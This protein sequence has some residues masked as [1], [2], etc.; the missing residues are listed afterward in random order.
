LYN[1]TTNIAF[2]VWKIS[3]APARHLNT[4]IVHCCRFDVLDVE[5]RICLNAYALATFCPSI[6]TA[7]LLRGKTSRRQMSS[8]PVIASD[9]QFSTRDIRSTRCMRRSHAR[10]VRDVDGRTTI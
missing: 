9:M 6:L 10:G 5:R 4:F 2:P 7:G 8:L 1:E 3:Q